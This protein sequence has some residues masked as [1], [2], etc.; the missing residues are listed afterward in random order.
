MAAVAR[1]DLRLAIRSITRKPLFTLV[2][3]GTLALGI[4]ASTAIFGIVDALLVRP[5]PFPDSQRLVS[6][7]APLTGLSV[8]N[9]GLSEPELEDL[10]DRSGVFDA[11]TPVWGFDTNLTGGE[12]PERIEALCV[13]P[14][15]FELL[16]A[17]PQLGRLF[18]PEDDARGFAEAAVISDA[19]W[20]TRFGTDP[21]I[22]GRSLRFDNDLYRIVGVLPADF[23]HPGPIR[24]GDVEVWVTA[25]FRAAPFPDPPIRRA[26]MFPRTIGRLAPGLTLAQAQAKL[27][28]FSEGLRTQYPNDYP[29]RAGWALTLVPV[30][31]ELTDNVRVTLLVIFG[32]VV[33]VLLIC[34]VN[35]TNMVLAR[36]SARSREFAVHR[37]LGAPPWMVVRRVLVEC[38]VLAG[39]GGAGALA[40]VDPLQRALLRL[41]PMNLPRV[42]E[43]GLDA[44]TLGFMALTTVV[45]GV[46]VGVIPAVLISRADLV[47]S[48]KEG[49]QGS[50]MGGGRGRTRAALVAC[51][52]GFSLALMIGAGLLGRSF[53]HLLDVDPGFEVQ[54]L[55]VANLWLP[56]PNDPTTSPY[57][58][59]DTRRAFIREVLRR[60]GQLPGVEAAAIGDGQSIPLV[61]FNSIPF[62][63]EGAT[64]QASEMPTAQ[65]TGVTPDFFRALGTRL[66][67]G[68]VFRESDDGDHLVVVIDE[69]TARRYWKD[70]DPIGRRIAFGQAGQ[71]RWLEIVGVVGAMKTRAFES[72]DAPHIYRSIYQGAGNAMSVFVR[73]AGAAAV[74]T[75]QLR[76]EV[77]AVDPDLPVFGV[78]TMQ[79][80]VSRS[81]ARRR[82]AS[83]LFGG[84][85]LVALLLAGLGIYGVTA[86]SVGQRTREIG[87]RMAL[88]AQPKDIMGM[89][90]R[91]GLSLTAAG[92]VGGVAAALLLTRA[93]RSLL[94]G[95]TPTDPLTYAAMSLV[96]AAVT[97]VACYAPARRALRVDPTVALHDEA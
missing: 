89:I 85:A 82:F 39:L 92:V 74:S 50:G 23:R 67:A 80:V 19:A 46:L 69:T 27:D 9:A 14:N 62:R 58:G 63:V 51:E 60:V 66:V 49:G 6:I 21:N 81:L 22:L 26:R 42:T 87:L 96:L 55:T 47:P 5:L 57:R 90:L 20:R 25:G 41:A 56:A 10:R 35:I 61:G 77:E 28:T 30:A 68:R 16:G 32:A 38:L 54:N 29:E 36:T 7:V 70:Q 64:E 13:S 4:G 59:Q 95:T 31:Q 43:V 94:F 93:L 1:V 12:K 52:I 73:T 44:G 3:V 72:P 8:P 48:L 2:V 40:I 86:V 65:L 78:R 76:R 88:G 34:C 84:F 17:R 71:P 83:T 53:A 37:S 45:C 79:Q 91:G 75:E 33:C 18:G 24:L 11:I 97:L 15:Y